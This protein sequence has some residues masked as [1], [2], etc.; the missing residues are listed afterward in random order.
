L[1]TPGVCVLI[2]Q[3]QQQESRR[4]DAVPMPRRRI[5]TTDER[6]AVLAH[7]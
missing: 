1:R 5:A 6:P 7:L 2:R 3:P 4:E